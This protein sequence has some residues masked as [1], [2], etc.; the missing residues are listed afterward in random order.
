MSG[1][2]II[3][4]GGLDNH[5]TI[6]LCYKKFRIIINR[7]TCWLVNLYKFNQ[8]IIKSIVLEF[9]LKLKSIF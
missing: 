7:V 8:L 5:N 3:E 4:I 9:A 2:E 1:P 6:N